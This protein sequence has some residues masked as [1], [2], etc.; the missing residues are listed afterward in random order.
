MRVNRMRA[1]HDAPHEPH[2]PHEED[3][4]QLAV[5]SSAML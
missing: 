5:S 4:G 2:E 3:N 1:I